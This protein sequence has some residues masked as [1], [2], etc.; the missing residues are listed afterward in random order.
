MKPPANAIANPSSTTAPVP[1]RPIALL[2]NDDGLDS[3]FLASVAAALS[4][5]CT[6]RIAAPAQEQSWISR[7]VSRHRP[8][9]VE[10]EN[11]YGCQAWRIDGTPTDCVNIALHHLLPEPPAIVVSG[12][13]IG[14]NTTLPLI[15]SSGTVAGALEA[16]G[17]GLHAVASSLMVPRE[18]FPQLLADRQRVPSELRESLFEAAAHTARFAAGLLNQAPERLVV[19]N[20]NFPHPTRPDT[21]LQSTKLADARLGGLF[22]SSPESGARTYNFCYN[23]GQAIPEQSLT[24]RSCLEQGNASHTRIDYRNLAS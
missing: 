20:L 7:A 2:T 11:L 4:E 13:N 17:W 23:A 10:E 15:L 24:D 5:F 14:F 21:I 1:T 3:C 9:K 12:I 16:S 8:V 6:V 22:Q 18:L 19:Q